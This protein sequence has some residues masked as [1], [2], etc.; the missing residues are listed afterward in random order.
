M[1]KE[2][3]EKAI[4]LRH[5]LHK[6]A[7]LSG[8]EVKTREYLMRF[9]KENTS[10]DLVDRGLWFY[11]KYDA[12][13][14]SEAIGYRADFDAISVDETID[15]SYSSVTKGVSHKCG[16][17]GHAATLV[18]FA[19]EIDKQGADK[20]IYFVFQHAEENGSGA[21][22]ASVIVDEA[23]ITEMYAFHNYPEI[24]FGEIGLKKGTVCFASM[25]M[26]IKLHG[27]SSHASEPEKGINP[28]YAVADII[29]SL[30][31]YTD[32][33][34]NKGLVLATIVQVEVG[35]EAFGVSAHEGKLLLTIRAEKGNELKKLKEDLENR[36]KE[37]AEKYG[38]KYEIEYSDV[39]PET[40]NNDVIIE[41]I[42]SIALL[43]GYTV[44]D[45]KAL[46]TS[47]DYGYFLQKTKG[48][49]MWIGAGEECPN[50]HSTDFD[51][52]DDLIEYVADLFM[53]IARS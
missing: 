16:H 5:E 53:M 14:P 11:A 1:K 22:F 6:L 25:G 51:F 49:M 18:A 28:A 44:N 41:K 20:D 26:I 33:K 12:N 47:E 13:N 9:L 2:N 45:I 48:A 27:V 37:E 40:S 23:N 50:L 52:N 35:E 19:M 10:L 24:P 8:K 31:D 3:L 32:N 4:K 46:R 29:N 38:L 34:K 39:F 30:S 7:E 36:I 21:E 15:I 43:N 17:D 42:R